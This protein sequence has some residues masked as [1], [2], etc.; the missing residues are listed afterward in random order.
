MRGGFL[1]FLLGLGLAISATSPAVSAEPNRERDALARLA[2]ELRVLEA[3]V[4]EAE[5][6]GDSS[7]RG[8]ASHRCHY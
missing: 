1:I 5:R 6:A 4:D 7:R 8:T 2:H 3:L